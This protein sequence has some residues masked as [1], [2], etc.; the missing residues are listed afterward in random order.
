MATY[1]FL[2][3]KQ[4]ILSNIWIVYPC[5]INFETR[6]DPLNRKSSYFEQTRA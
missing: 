4:A 5:F 3:A 1:D 2:S 6:I